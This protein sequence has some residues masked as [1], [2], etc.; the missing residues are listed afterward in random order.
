MPPEARR[1]Q[2][3]DAAIEIIARD[4]YAGVSIDS[5]AREAGVTRPVVYGVFDGLK[6]L[7]YALLD[8]QE[9]RALEQL[10]TAL[11]ADLANG[12]PAALIVATARRLAESV[13]GDPSTWRPIL[14]APE[15]TPQ[16][17]R[18]RIARDRELVRTRIM[19]LLDTIVA[20]RTAPPI[21]TEIASHAVIGVAEYFGRLLVD[22][23]AAVDAE[24]LVTAIDGL[25][26]VVV[27]GP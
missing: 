3:L 8:R 26:A 23:P 4:G 21:D 18:E 1:E 25:L 27:I 7:L 14:L 19:S 15:G 9:E 13:V 6:A 12:D 24:R 17:V 16:A 10:L 5:I 11:P 20:Q 22:Q 2:L